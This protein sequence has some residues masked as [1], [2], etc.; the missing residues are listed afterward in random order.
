[1]SLPSCTSGLHLALAALGIG[2]GDEVITRDLH[3]DCVICPYLVCRGTPVFADVE[4]DTWCLSAASLE[5]CITPRTKAVIVVDLYG[6]VA[7]YDAIRRIA[8]KHGVAVIEDAAEAVGAEYKG[9]RAGSLGD[10]GVFRLPPLEDA[11]HG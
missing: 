11:H 2:S 1:M 9:K 6:G 4:P 10:V 5:Q 7:D 8:A 3:L